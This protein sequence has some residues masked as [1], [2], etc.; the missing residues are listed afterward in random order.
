M[1]E[2]LDQPRLAD[3]GLA[4]H[5]E[6]L[7]A[8]RSAARGERRFELAQLAAPPHHDLRHGSAGGAQPMQPPG[9]HGLGDAFDLE[10]PYRVAVQALGEGAADILRDQHLARRRQVG[11]ARG[12][13]HRVAG[14][15]IGPVPRTAGAARHHLAAG[16]ADVDRDRPSEALGERRHRVPDRQS[17]ACGPLGIVA[18][19]HRRAE[20][21][22][23]AVADML[24][25]GSAVR[26]D[27]AVGD[28]EEAFDQ[29][30]QFLGVQ[31]PRKRG[32]ADEVGE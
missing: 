4:A 25:H 29:V 11:Q 22:H 27:H 6:R 16:H 14:D 5:V 10:R 2:L 24:V 9:R 18:M 7:T 13:V 15:R 8:S 30:V 12:Q 23:D 21:A 26:L 31:L 32:V 1:R 20:H 3:A 19:R 17:R 28:R